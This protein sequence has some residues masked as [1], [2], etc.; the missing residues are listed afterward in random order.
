MDLGK[1]S[2]FSR[3]CCEVAVASFGFRCDFATVDGMLFG[4][5]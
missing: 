4:V 3:P 5:M 1:V 2:F